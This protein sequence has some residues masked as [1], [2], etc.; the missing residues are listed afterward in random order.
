[1]VQLVEQ[2]PLLGLGLF[3]LADI[4]QQ[5]D[6]PD[7]LA[8]AVAKRCRI[9]NE[10]NPGS[11][12]T[13]RH[14][15][16]VADGAALFE[17]DRH[18]ALV[19]RERRAVRMVKLPRDAPFVA[20]DRRSAARQFHSRLIEIG[21]LALR[22]GRVDRRRHS[23]DQLLELPL[24]VAEPGLGQLQR[25]RSFGHTLLEGIVELTQLPLSATP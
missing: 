5:I 16:G 8:G 17:S 7:D 24:A 13:L 19:I 11:V 6:R 25:S 20:A 10:G 15:F 3:A 22:V 4:H 12:G 9:W 14:D 23:R 1:M 21:N 18:G 2:D